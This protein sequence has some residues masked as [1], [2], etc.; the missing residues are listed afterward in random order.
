[1]QKERWSPYLTAIDVDSIIKKPNKSEVYELTKERKSITQQLHLM[2]IRIKQLEKEEKK[3]TLRAENAYA[4]TD[5][6][7]KRRFEKKQKKI[8]R[9]KIKKEKEQE[10]E[11]LKERNREMNEEIKTKLTIKKKKILENKKTSAKMVKDVNKQ[12][13]LQMPDKK[14]L[15]N[16]SAPPKLSVINHKFNDSKY[17]TSKVEEEKEKTN[18]AFKEMNKL[19]EVEI[20]LIEKLNEVFEYRKNAEN[21]VAYLIN[22]PIIASKKELENISLNNLSEIYQ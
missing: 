2:K 22:H 3:A 20:K 21:K 11:E 6:I 4:L 19:H 7:I 1:M 17:S 15:R 9:E 13:N 12:Q 16:S 10:I 18:E 5:M 8:L 14:S